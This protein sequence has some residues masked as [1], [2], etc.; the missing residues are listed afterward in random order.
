MRFE[1]VFV[2]SFCPNFIHF[3]IQ[4]SQIEDSQYYKWGPHFHN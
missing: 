4:L 3:E 2:I 1:I